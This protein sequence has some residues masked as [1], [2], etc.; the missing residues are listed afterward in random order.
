VEGLL[1]EKSSTK[2]LSGVLALLLAVVG[3][4][5]WWTWQRAES[6]EEMTH[7]ALEGSDPQD[8]DYQEKAAARLVMRAGQL[9]KTG[10]R[11]AAQPYLTRLLMESK[12]PAVRAEGMRGLSQIRDYQSVPTMLELLNDPSPQVRR[13]AGLAIEGLIQAARKFNADATPEERK[14][15]IEQLRAMWKQFNERTLKGWQKRLE[16]VDAKL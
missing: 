12:N 5:F 2:V 10:P 6:L 11:N 8:A 13:A 16:A 4:R 15:E 1:S 7:A 3:A 14:K 9:P